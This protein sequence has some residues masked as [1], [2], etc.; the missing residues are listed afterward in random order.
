MDLDTLISSQNQQWSDPNWR[1][2]EAMWFHRPHYYETLKAALQTKLT[3]VL[4][5]LRRVGKSTLMRQLLA[6]LLQ[7]SSPQTLF[8]FSFDEAIIKQETDTLKVLL[9]RYATLMWHQ[10]LMF[11]KDRLFIFLDEIQY[12]PDWQSVIKTYRDLNPQLQFIVS[13]ST[14]LFIRQ[15]TK[16][17]LAGRTSELFVRPLSFIEYAAIHKKLQSE[18]TH[19]DLVKFGTLHPHILTYWFEQYLLYGQFPEPVTQDYS[20]EIT[21]NYIK[22]IQEKVLDVD[23]PRT[24]PIKRPDILKIIFAHFSENS[25]ALTTYDSLTNDLGIDVRTTRDYVEW[26]IQAFLLDTCHNVTKKIVKAARTS[27]KVYLTSTNFSQNLPL[28]SQVETYVFNFLRNLQPHIRTVEFFRQK[29]QEVDFM[30]VSKS[31]KKIPIEVKYQNQIT[32]ADLNSIKQFID[33]YHSP[34]AFLIT[35]NRA[36]KEPHYF[37]KVQIINLTAATL[38]ESENRLK[39]KFVST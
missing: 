2:E 10:P 4:T 26:L 37:Q 5:G 7:T 19:R 31:G 20:K 17:S 30:V 22:Q 27:K 1:P 15:K 16:E 8:Y 12:I 9:E 24:F 6:E 23:L 11:I 29:N 32:E 36:Y 3:V 25:G 14:S 38:E 28:G 33:K 18:L 13:G 34:Y 39:Q 21:V 35:K